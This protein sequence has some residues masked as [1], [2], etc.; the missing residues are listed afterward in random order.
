MNNFNRRW[1]HRTTGRRYLWQL[2]N[3]VV[4][5]RVSIGRINTLC[6]RIRLRDRVCVSGCYGARVC[7]TKSTN[8]NDTST[9]GVDRKA[10][11]YCTFV[12]CVELECSDDSVRERLNRAFLIR[13]VNESRRDNWICTRHKKKS[14]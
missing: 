1:S 14:F 6:A 5:I 3:I 9:G 10:R 13:A 8:Q 7:I 12:R 4:F 2:I 11:L